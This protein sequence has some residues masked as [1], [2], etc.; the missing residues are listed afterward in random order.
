MNKQALLEALA[1]K[2]GMSVLE[3]LEEGTFDS[4]AWGIC[5]ECH[6]STVVEPDQCAG[7]CE[8][9][10]TNTVVSCLVLAEII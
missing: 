7:Y 2:C 3:M 4:V 10:K 1:A 5:P 6:Y 9:C 8:H